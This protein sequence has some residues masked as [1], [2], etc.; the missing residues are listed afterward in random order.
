VVNVYVLYTVS[1]G[2]MPSGFSEI[3]STYHNRHIKLGDSPLSTG[4]SA[5]HTHTGSVSSSSTATSGNAYKSTTGSRVLASQSH[6]HSG[7]TV[8]SITSSDDYMSSKQ[9]RLLYRSVDGWD[10]LIP[11]YG[12]VCRNSLPDNDW[13]RVDY[14]GYVIIAG[15][16]WSTYT[17]SHSH[18]FSM[19][20]NAYSTANQVDGITGTNYAAYNHGHN[21]GSGT[22]TSTFPDDFYNVITRIIV[23]SNRPKYVTKD[24]ILLFD[25]DPGQSWDKVSGAA[26]CYLKCGDSDW[27]TGGSYSTY[28]HTHTV[29]G[30][31]SGGSN[32]NYINSGT[33]NSYYMFSSSHTHTANVTLNS[34]TI[35]PPWFQLTPYKSLI[36]F[37]FTG[38]PVAIFN[39]CVRSAI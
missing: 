16:A 26:N 27:T 19:T 32:L 34:S 18:N 20:L 9:F 3:S 25:G 4:G 24:S 29:N 10:G 33:T 31:T 12:A 28:S 11:K 37:S 13:S 5:S 30:V 36:D 39:D 6:T 17:S 35:E 2:D 22:A 8:S 1:G 7:G 21:A 23:A 38:L 15:V 14:T